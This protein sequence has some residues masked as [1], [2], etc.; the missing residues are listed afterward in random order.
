[1]SQSH[2]LSEGSSSNGGSSK[3]KV[4]HVDLSKKSTVSS[5]IEDEPDQ[6]QKV[7]KVK[8][9]KKDKKEKEKEKEKEPDD[10]EEDDEEE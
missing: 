9:E 1:M 4:K 6:V 3:N 10:D 7:K 2:S 8:E 5:V